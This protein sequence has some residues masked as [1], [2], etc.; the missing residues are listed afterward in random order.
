MGPHGAAGRVLERRSLP[1]GEMFSPL[2]GT[3]CTTLCAISA[4]VQE[5]QTAL[6]QLPARLLPPA[7]RASPAPCV[8]KSIGWRGTNLVLLAHT[9]LQQ[10]QVDWVRLMQLRRLGSHTAS[11]VRARR[12]RA[13][14]ST[15]AQ[16]Q[17]RLFR[18]SIP[19]S[20]T[21]HHGGQ[22]HQ[23]RQH[24]PDLERVGP[25]AAGARSAGQADRAAAGVADAPGGPLPAGVPPAPQ[26]AGRQHRRLL[27]RDPRREHGSRPHR[28]A[29]HAFRGRRGHRVQ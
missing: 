11:T 7:V 21:H 4:P 19:A 29:R 10:G 6:S 13:A 14:G 27:R 28:P 2:Y 26:G 18:T 23:R 9:A 17:R 3:G 16:Q 25:A 5:K 24:G 22:Q 12:G 15:T 8:P 1:P 20:S